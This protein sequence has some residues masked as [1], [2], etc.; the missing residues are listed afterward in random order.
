MNFTKTPFGVF[1]LKKKKFYGSKQ[2]RRAYVPQIQQ[3]NRD[4]ASR[5]IYLRK[6]KNN[7]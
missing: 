5:E 3:Q 1:R 7:F 4:V 2:R 6:S